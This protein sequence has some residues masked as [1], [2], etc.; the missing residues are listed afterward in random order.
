MN[1]IKFNPITEQENKNLNEMKN[2]AMGE[3]S[4]QSISH[5]AYKQNTVG[6]NYEV[7]HEIQIR[8][9]ANSKYNDCTCK[10]STVTEAMTEVGKMLMSLNE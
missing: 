6:N 5:R 8:T 1:V 7:N 3:E 9:F 4:I 10:G 2:W